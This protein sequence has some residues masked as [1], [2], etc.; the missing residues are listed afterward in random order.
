MKVMIIYDSVFGN[1]EKVAKV[2]GEALGSHE[3]VNVVR[4]TDVKP[5]QLTG[6]DILIVGSPTRQ[7]KA[8]P[9]INDSVDLVIIKI[10]Y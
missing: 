5:E 1:T 8:T 4:V 6:L 7:F 9:A 3:D 10:R 2:M